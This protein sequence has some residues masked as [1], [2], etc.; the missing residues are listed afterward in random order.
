MSRP[1]N[2]VPKF[3]VD[4]TGRAFTK[5]D[6]RFFS[7]G[8]ADSPESRIRFAKILEDHAKGVLTRTAA[9]P[10]EKRGGMC[11]SELL[12]LY[13]GKELP[14]FSPSERHCQTTAMRVLKE[15]F[16]ETLVEEFGP[17]R[18]RVVRDSMIAGDAGA[19]NSRGKPDSRR[20]WS[21]KTVNRQ[22]KRLQAIFRWGVSFEIV[23][24]SIATALG[25]LRVLKKGETTATESIPRSAVPQADIDAARAKLKPL[26]QDVFDLIR[27]TAARPGEILDL[28]SGMIDR[29]GETWVVE[30]MTHKNQHK[31]KARHL[32]FNKAAQA[33]LLR[34]LSFDPDARIFPVRRDNFGTAVKRAC[35]K[36]NVP[37]F[38]PHQLRHSAI[39]KIVDQVGFAEAQAIAG[40]S[41]A[42][43]TRHYSR[44]AI[45][46]AKRGALALDESK[47]LG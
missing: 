26:H 43:M 5:V 38:C 29:R 36:A 35:V 15:L 41:S 28:R 40:H 20:P 44:A 6:G 19:K 7:L 10:P 37:T 31:D 27:L 3:S 12:L 34:H 11:I 8:R 46:T 33:V 39:S 9:K 16:G 17:L 13:A 1:K 32:I 24:D 45:E 47:K 25:T 23:P 22:I 18:L 4:N 30:L 14:R 2:S 21:R 42:E